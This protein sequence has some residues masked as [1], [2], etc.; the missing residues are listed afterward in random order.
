M[1]P[2]VTHVGADMCKQDSG[3]ENLYN[4]PNVASPPMKTFYNKNNAVAQPYATTTLI[5]NNLGSPPGA[6]SAFRPIQ[7]GYVQQPGNGS[8]SSDSC[9]KQDLSTDSTDNNRSHSGVCLHHANPD[10]HSEYNG[11]HPGRMS[12]IIQ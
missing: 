2:D 5:A 9:Q 11:Y 4:L 6:D 10:Y 8:G 7:Q 12:S 1:P 3:S